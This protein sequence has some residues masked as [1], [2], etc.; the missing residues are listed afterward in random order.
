MHWFIALDTNF[1]LHYKTPKDIDWKELLAANKRDVFSIVVPQIVLRELDKHKDSREGKNRKRARKAQRLMHDAIDSGQMEAGGLKW[2]FLRYPV[3]FDFKGSGLTDSVPDD[4]FI[5]SCVQFARD[6]KPERFVVVTADLGLKALAIIFQEL[7]DVRLPDERDRLPD[8]TREEK[9]IAQLKR[10]ISRLENRMPILE[11]RFSETESR[12]LDLVAKSIPVEPTQEIIAEKM[13]ELKAQFPSRGPD[14][15][16]KKNFSGIYAQ[17]ARNIS[18]EEYE[19][20]EEERQTYFLAYADYMRSL[21]EYERKERRRFVI[22]LELVNLGTAPAEDI[23]I[24]LHFPDGLALSVAEELPEGPEPPR[25]PAPP[26]GRRPAALSNFSRLSGLFTTSYLPNPVS[27]QSLPIQRPNTTSPKI[28]RTNSYDV[29]LHTLYLK[30]HCSDKIDPF[31]VEFDTDECMRPFTI[32][33][34]LISESLPDPVTGCL[35]VNVF[36]L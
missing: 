18:P 2:L 32:D 35:N 14:Q 26:S 13:I 28:R 24:H 22:L 11:V 16:P 29:T 25:I 10:Q 34:R 36:E 17:F 15:T 9:E 33:Y 23:D 30:Q 3:N 5:A 12:N 27:L 1:Y 8:D 21:Y 4:I 19:R 31:L 20:Y 6:S 7:R